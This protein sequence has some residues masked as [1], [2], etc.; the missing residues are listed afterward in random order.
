MQLARRLQSTEKSHRRLR[1]CHVF[2]GPS[3]KS[4]K[5]SFSEPLQRLEAPTCGPT[6]TLSTMVTGQS[7]VGIGVADG[8]GGPAVIAPTGAQEQQAN[9]TL[10]PPIG[11]HPP[12]RQAR[13]PLLVPRIRGTLFYSMKTLHPYD[14]SRSHG[15]WH[16]TPPHGQA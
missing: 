7:A 16:L 4:E 15:E 6:V 12:L 14:A 3:R 5:L 9:Q 13:G 11:S 8:I 10:A 1:Q 2:S